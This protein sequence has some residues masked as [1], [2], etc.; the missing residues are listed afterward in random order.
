MKQKLLA[1]F[2][3][4]ICLTPFIELLNANLIRDNVFLGN[5]GQFYKGAVLAISFVLLT[6]KERAYYL[7]SIALGL[8]FVFFHVLT[9]AN[10]SGNALAQ[11]ILFVVKVTY[12]IPLIF[13]LRHATSTFIFWANAIG[14]VTIVVNILLGYVGFGFTQYALGYGYKGFFY[15]GNE[16]ALTL[17]VTSATILYLL[18]TSGKKVPAFAF[19]V[20]LLILGPLQGMKSLLLGLPL[21]TVLIPFILYSKPI[22]SQIKGLSLTKKIGATVASIMIL[23]AG[24]WVLSITSPQFFIRVKEISERSGIVAAVF[25]ERDKHLRFGFT[26]YTNDYSIVEKIVGKGYLGAQQG[27]IPYMNR[28]KTIEVDPVDL[29]FTFGILS[30]VYYT[31][32]ITALTS[33]KSR[34]SADRFILSIN[35]LLLALSIIT[36]HVVYSTFLATYWAMLF[37]LGKKHKATN[38]HVYFLGS[39]A[40]G[41]IATYIKETAAQAKDTISI[42]ILPTHTDGPLRNTVQAFTRS[43]VL[44]ATNLLLNVLKGQRSVI[45]LHM[46]TGGSFIRKAIILFD[47]SWFA[48]KTIL[49]LHSG[50]APKFFEK[51]LK[52]TGGRWLLRT[53]FNRCNT[54]AV[55]SQTL[56]TQI[57]DVFS[58]YR[59]Q[60]ACSKWHVLPNAITIPS[61][62]RE[63]KATTQKEP[64]K[65]VTVSRLAPVK[66]LHIIPK[67]AALI[68]EQNIP[69]SI[70]IVGDGPEK[71]KILREILTYDVGDCVNLV[72]QVPHE[73]ITNVYSNAHIFLLPS[74]YESF[75]IVVLEAYING[76]TA[77]TSAVGGLNDLVIEG[78]TGFRF[79]PDDAQ[80]FADAIVKLAVDR[81][82]LHTM[83]V[84]AQKS[85]LNYNYSDHITKLEQLYA[86]P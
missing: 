35:I 51:I 36:G 15:S 34:T 43:Y 19:S 59:L 41:G 85:A 42:K 65:I 38:P 75:G 5:V 49:H 64:L 50:E 9:G 10:S 57:S 18:Y 20:T 72:G 83:Q 73:E 81:K 2:F 63:V 12:I 67:I 30:V 84:A 76:L 26:M 53:V 13:L 86:H 68:K 66:N 61:K 31:C 27:M 37:A 52:R 28:L 3:I 21:L 74:L 46:A 77:I 24:M 33:Y 69:F 23:L 48:D 40:M 7:F 11:D 17:L 79:A 71:T 8:L 32:W 6:K 55:V 39:T 62:L 82:L 29:L 45:H 70:D 1:L 54:V 80:G 78:K 58:Q 4:L 44:L 60:E 56:L 25:S 47:L 16:M 14:W 22:L